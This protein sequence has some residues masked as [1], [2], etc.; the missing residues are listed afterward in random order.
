MMGEEEKSTNFCSHLSTWLPFDGPLGNVGNFFIDYVS[1]K[2]NGVVGGID[3]GTE[4]AHL[5]TNQ[6]LGFLK[7]L[8]IT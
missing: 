6:G 7:F 1:H 8:L 5:C 3:V 2:Q 4:T